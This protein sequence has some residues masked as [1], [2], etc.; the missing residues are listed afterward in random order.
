MEIEEFW[1]LYFYYASF[2]DRQL[3]LY[4]K[5][6]NTNQENYD[7][8]IW[9]IN[10]ENYNK[11]EFKIWN[12]SIDKIKKWV[13]YE[14]KKSNKH[15]KWSIDQ[16]ENYMYLLKNKYNIKINKGILKIKDEK[17]IEIMYNEELEKHYKEKIKKIKEILKSKKIPPKKDN[18]NICKKCWYYEKCYI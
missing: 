15:I 10:Q 6:I 9:K 16:L 12:I 2:C 18:I 17:D 13:I 14:Y 11:E 3:W 5:G 8:I 7:I 4:N 1:W